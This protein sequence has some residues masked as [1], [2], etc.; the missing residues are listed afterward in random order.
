MISI[1]F[2]PVLPRGF[3]LYT[4]GVLQRSIVQLHITA[5]IICIVI[6]IMERSSM[7]SLRGLFIPSC[8]LRTLTCIH[9]EFKLLKFKSFNL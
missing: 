5:I 8:S 7:S 6:R 2:I 3:A 4:I 1:R 9:F